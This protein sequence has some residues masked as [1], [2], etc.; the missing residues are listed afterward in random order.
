[1]ALSLWVLMRPYGRR[2][3]IDS[4]IKIDYKVLTNRSLAAFFTQILPHNRPIYTA[5]MT[6]QQARYAMRLS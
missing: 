4:A 6:A 3:L 5:C 2:R 1:M